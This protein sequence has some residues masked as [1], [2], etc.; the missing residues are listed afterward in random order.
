MVGQCSDS[1]GRWRDLSP[2]YQVIYR[3]EYSA[4]RVS[5]G[6]KLPSMDRWISDRAR[7]E[8]SKIEEADK[9]ERRSKR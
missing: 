6:E 2:V 3:Y 9:G 1:R 5:E 8:N 4:F 7:G